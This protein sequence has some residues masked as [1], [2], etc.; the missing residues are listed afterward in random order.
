LPALDENNISEKAGLDPNGLTKNIKSIFFSD[1]GE[2]I[3]TPVISKRSIDFN[4]N[5]KDTD[6]GLTLDLNHDGFPHDGLP[7]ILTTQNDWKKLKFKSANIGSAASDVV[8]FPEEMPI[9]ELKDLGLYP[10]PQTRFSGS[11]RVA[12]AN[13]IAAQGWPTGASTVILASGANFADALAA[14]PLAKA[15]DAS[16]LLTSN[17]ASLEDTVLTTISTLKASKV[18]IVGGG[19]SVK[20]D[21]ETL[22]R[23]V[24]KLTVER[25]SGGNRYTTAIAIAEKL[26][27]KGVSFTSTFLADGTNFPYA[28]AVS[29]VA[30]ILQQPILFTN[31]GD[32]AKVNANTGDYIKSA[33][34]KTVN[35]VGGGISTA[36]ENNLK[37]AY[38]V[39][40]IKSLSGANRYATAVA[41]NAEYKSIFTGNAVT[42]TTG[43]NFPDA[44]AGSAYAA[45]IG[46]PLFFLQNN[47]TLENVKSA[48]QGINPSAV[49]IFGGAVNDATVN[50]HI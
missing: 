33:G 49:Y 37:S 45:K 19:G 21:F 12:T 44:L 29:P 50:N 18:I 42:L 6:T 47:A 38:G 23:D 41:I 16:I 10:T 26:K 4:L 20:V 32:T 40:G 28:L 14:A 8:H 5:G 25:V 34:I 35:I 48:K 30:G 24:K 3:T 36:V 11:N 43:A 27:A 46:A 31:K 15:Y 17:G 22:L 1:K 2:V 7:S 9:S 13:T 39:T